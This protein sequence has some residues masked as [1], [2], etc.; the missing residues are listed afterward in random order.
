MTRSDIM[1]LLK[2]QLWPVADYRVQINRDKV[3][4]GIST[5]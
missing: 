2:E 3:N 4:L 5:D 1:S